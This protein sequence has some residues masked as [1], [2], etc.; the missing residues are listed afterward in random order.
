MQ[1]SVIQTRYLSF[2][3]GYCAST[4]VLLLLYSNILQLSSVSV[5][6][7]ASCI[8]NGLTQEF[9]KSF[10]TNHNRHN[11]LQ[12]R[13]FGRKQTL[14]LEI[15]QHKQR[16][17]TSMKVSVSDEHGSAGNI[18]RQPQMNVTWLHL[19]STPI[20]VVS[21]PRSMWGRWGTRTQRASPRASQ[22]TAFPFESIGA[23]RCEQSCVWH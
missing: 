20:P 14:M 21:R 3:S 8:S 7:C 19:T 1:Y 18:P 6:L 9:K 13:V 22:K 15:F 10:I 17:K 12:H 16:I 5:I 2:N 4:V 11:L 23:V